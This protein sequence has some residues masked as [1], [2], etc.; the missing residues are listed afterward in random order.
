MALTHRITRCRLLAFVAA[1]SVT[2]VGGATSAFAYDDG[3]QNVFSSVLTAVGVMP[4]E[5]TPDIDY[6]ERPPLVVP[7]K[8]AIAA[9]KTALVKPQAAGAGRTAAWPQDPDVIRRRKEADEIGLPMISMFDKR[10]ADQ[11]PE[12]KEEMLKH[13]AALNGP[14]DPSASYCREGEHGD[15]H[16]RVG[17]AELKAQGERYKAQNPSST[18]DVVTAGIEPERKYLTEPPPGYRK[19]TKTVKATAEAPQPAR[20]QSSPLSSYINV[21]KP[22][23]SEN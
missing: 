12:S 4:A 17:P 2:G 1:L 14:D 16:C 23:D 22:D 20:D 6:R 5:R 15:G 19:A 13:R 8:T 10:E 18:T 9:P 3:Y 11:R 7:P 21:P